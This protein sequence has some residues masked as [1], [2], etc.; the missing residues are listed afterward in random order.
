[1][2]TLLCLGTV[3]VLSCAL[4][5]FVS[6]ESLTDGDYSYTVLDDST[7]EITK[8]NGTET[9]VVIPDTLGGYT[10]TS[11]GKEAF[12]NNTTILSVD[13]ADTVTNIGNYAFSCC[14]NLSQ[15]KLNEGLQTLG[16]FSFEKCDSVEFVNIPS[17]V[18]SGG[19]AMGAFYECKKLKSI[20]NT[21]NMLVPNL[22]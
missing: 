2:K 15:I 17:T 13:F 10:V 14:S 22:E 4:L 9:D 6:A 21:D 3:L 19:Y 16:A 8:Y 12:K 11:I 1:M 7:A 20:Y 18:I 5:C